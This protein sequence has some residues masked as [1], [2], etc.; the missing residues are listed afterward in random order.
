M[1]I[2]NLCEHDS[3]VGQFMS[4]IRDKDIQKERLRF[5]ANIKRLGQIMAYEISKKLHYKT[6]ETTTSLGVAQTNVLDD[7]VVLATI[8]RA[9]LPF[10]EGFLS[11]FDKAENGFVSAYRKYR[12]KTNEFDV[13]I[14]YIA[15]P[16]I[17]NKTLLIV[18]PMLATGS[19]MDLA[20]QALMTK[21]HPS[22]IHV[23]SVIATDEAIEL[24]RSSLPEDRTTLWTCDIDHKMNE[25]SYIIPG[26]GDAGDLLFGEKE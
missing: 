18:D 15:C 17:D 9:G 23:A 16:R 13:H 11:Y 20:F 8:L 14:E 19:S 6:I 1:E 4:E 3:L 10:H 2:I 12:E 26:L 7:Q 24:I 21:G 25:H 5:R 22:H